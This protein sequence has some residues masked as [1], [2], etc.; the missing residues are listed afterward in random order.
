MGQVHLNKVTIITRI[1]LQKIIEDQVLKQS[2]HQLLL[3]SKQITGVQEAPR[4]RRG[5]H[6]RTTR[7]T[8]EGRSDAATNKGLRGAFAYRGDRSGARK[9]DAQTRGRRG[10]YRDRVSEIRAA[11]GPGR[12]ERRK[13]SRLSPRR[14]P[15]QGEQIAIAGLP[16]RGLRRPC[17]RRKKESKPL[18][19]G[20]MSPIHLMPSSVYVVELVTP[21][22]TNI[23]RVEDWVFY[24]W[25]ISRKIYL[26]MTSFQE[27]CETYPRAL[28]H[29]TP[30]KIQSRPGDVVVLRPF[31]YFFVDSL[32]TPDPDT[33]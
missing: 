27:K 4:R 18:V 23:A 19:V 15:G 31:I 16:S 32:D 28:T 10:D 25:V 6:E 7:R 14:R 9:E 1:K 3:F 29:L 11:A 17:D 24:H 20:H 12:R 33:D 13:R 22:P 26:K 5:A 8:R 30:A 21:L 2:G